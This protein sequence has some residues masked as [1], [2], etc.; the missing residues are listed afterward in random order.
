MLDVKLASFAAAYAEHREYEGRR[1]AEA[2]L[3]ALPWLR[4]GPHARQW[5]VRARTFETFLDRLLEPTAAAMARPLTV[6]DLGAGNGWLSHR[7][8]ALGHSAIALDIRGD[9][10]DG[11]GAGDWPTHFERILASFDA[12][13]LADDSTDMTVFNA[14]LHYALDLPA[15]LAEAKRVTRCG[16][17]IA[18]LDSPFYRRES[19]G[20]AMVAEKR[21]SAREQFGDR[22]EALTSLDCIEFLTP[23]RLAAASGME[24]RRRR[25]LYP[26]AYELRPLVAALS[27]RRPPSRFDLW[28]AEVR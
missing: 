17:T 14:S 24:W 28:T 9:D 3:L 2:D 4:N 18:I 8:A 21:G 10:V 13:P 7:V 1:L 27:G 16:G 6:L 15:A 26:L 23:A 22:A 5:A 11:L 20:E 12:I 19:D 25:V